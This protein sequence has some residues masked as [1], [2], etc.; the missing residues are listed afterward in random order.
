MARVMTAAWPVPELLLLGVA[1]IW[2]A[3]YSAVK[4]ATLHLPV[5]EFLSLRFAL[6][7]LCCYLRCGPCF[8]PA[9]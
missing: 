3:S 4:Y 8:G 1:A 7:L 6:T 2:G 9:A 5:L